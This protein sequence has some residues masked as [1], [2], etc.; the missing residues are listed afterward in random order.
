MYKLRTYVQT[1]YKTTF[2]GTKLNAPVQNYI[3][4]LVQNYTLRY[5]ITHSGTKLHTQVQNYTLRYKTI[6]ILR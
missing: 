2:S 1:T 6:G 4:N 3:G 5:K